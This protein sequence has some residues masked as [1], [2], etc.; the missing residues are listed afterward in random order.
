MHL[1]DAVTQVAQGGS[2]W[3]NG[4]TLAKLADGSLWSWGND[5]AGQLGNG[6]L[7]MSPV[8]VRFYAPAGVKY[9]SLAT[10]SAT[11][12]AVSADGKVYAWGVSY[13]GQL[14][15]GYLSIALAPVVIASGAAF[16][17]ATANNALIK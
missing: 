7:G 11:S 5:R 14:G 8:P 3:D 12:Y 9:T 15:N 16:V 1:P 6:S 10:G 2:I 17:S 4:Q 13:E